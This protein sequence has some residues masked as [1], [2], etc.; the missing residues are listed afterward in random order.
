MNADAIYVSAHQS[1]VKLLDEIRAESEEDVSR[2]LRTAISYAEEMKE[3]FL[4]TSGGS[5]AQ[6]S[7]LDAHEPPPFLDVLRRCEVL[8]R[9]GVPNLDQVLFAR[10][11]GLHEVDLVRLVRALEGFGL[12]EALAI[13]RDAT[14]RP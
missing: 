7:R 11:E 3:V 13:V 4:R 8:K 10:S 1:L 9:L 14:S 2:R 5:A 12:P 6:P